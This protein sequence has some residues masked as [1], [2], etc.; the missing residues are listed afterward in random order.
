MKP[1]KYQGP[2]LDNWGTP[3]KI[4]NLVATLTGA[5]FDLACE[6]HNRRFPNGFIHPHQDALA[7]PWPK[8]QVCF[9][10]PPFSQA[11][12]FFQKAASERWRGVKLMA[13]YKSN[14]LETAT[15]QDWILPNADW[16]LF[17]NQRSRF[18]PPPDF[19]GDL[20]GPGFSCA[21][22]SFGIPATREWRQ[23]GTILEASF[24]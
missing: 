2:R 23:H 3:D 14:N 6:E 10:N 4:V 17:L 24:L 22:I 15:W 7:L 8:D 18:I 11:A 13:L 12:D 9:L 19:E 16:F 21:L 1:G 20:H 5:T